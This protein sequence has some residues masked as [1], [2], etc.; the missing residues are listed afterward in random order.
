MLASRR[1]SG[2]MTYCPAGCSA[3]PIFWGDSSNGK[4]KNRNGYQKLEFV[5]KNLLDVLLTKTLRIQCTQPALLICAKGINVM[6]DK[7]FRSGYA[8]LC[9]VLFEM[10]RFRIRLIAIAGI[11]MNIS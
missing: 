1:L 5:Y 4:P 11:D 8:I 3:G 7:R 2:C 9:W 10:I 6:N